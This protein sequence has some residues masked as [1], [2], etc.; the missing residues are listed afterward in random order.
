MCVVAEDWTRLGRAVAARRLAL[1][2]TQEEVASRAGVARDTI[3]RLEAG[4]AARRLS[5]S[6]I[7]AVL[8]WAA[9]SATRVLGGDEPVLQQADG[10]RLRVTSVDS[11][12]GTV[13]YSVPSTATEEEVQAG[14]DDA[15]R[16]ALATAEAL[17]DATRAA[18]F[19]SIIEQRDR[20]RTE[21][22]P[23]TPPH[24]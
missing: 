14:I 23:D 2:L 21:G 6:K 10:Q 15:L 17:G 11:Q 5:L 1:T 20:N 13:A 9:G 4:K 3:V 18:Q 12:S 7:E 8:G 24:Q 19:R 22:D 16:V